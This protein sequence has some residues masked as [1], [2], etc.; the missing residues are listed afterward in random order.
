MSEIDKHAK[1]IWDYQVLHQDAKPSDCIIAL[2]NSDFRTA[3]RA[4]ELFMQG[5]GKWLVACGGFGR[6]TAHAFAKP[7]AHIF[8]DI[9]I[10]AGVPKD[11]IIIEDQST[12]TFDNILFAKT[13]LLKNRVKVNSVIVVT[14]PY[15]ERRAHAMMQK[16]WP[17]VKHTVASPN[18]TFENY[19]NKDITKTQFINLM[20]GDLQRII[21]YGKRGSLR[22]QAIPKEVLVSY[23]KLIKLGYNKQLVNKED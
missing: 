16:L 20:V 11:K 5:Y 19:S 14:K 6:I 10:V 23:Q 15:M 17:E 3:S 2:G 21:V 8:A 22:A 1:V 18:L 7:E 13:L 12:N 4:A 9:A